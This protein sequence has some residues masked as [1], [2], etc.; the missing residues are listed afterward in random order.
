MPYCSPSGR[1]TTLTSVNSA[2]H[3]PASS[4]ANLAARSDGSEWSTAQTIRM[5]PTPLLGQ[6]HTLSQKPRKVCRPSIGKILVNLFLH[7]R[8]PR[9]DLGQRI[10]KI[11]V[12]QP[13]WKLNALAS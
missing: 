4:S 7:A 10:R 8:V 5:T 1:R 9:I 12:G 3:L 2:A 6:S 11:G 13:L